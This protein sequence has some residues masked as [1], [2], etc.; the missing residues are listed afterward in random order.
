[1]L[2]QEQI[3]KLPRINLRFF[4]LFL[5]LA[6]MLFVV[7]VSF[8]LFLF[9]HLRCLNNNVLPTA[10]IKQKTYGAKSKA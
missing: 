2:K 9:K 3:T 10:K 5:A 8:Y 4:V 1:V 6:K 7:V